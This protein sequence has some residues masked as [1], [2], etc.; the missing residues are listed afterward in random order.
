MYSH[1][2]PSSKTQQTQQNQQQDN[3]FPHNVQAEETT[4]GALIIDPDAILD[5]RMDEIG[6]TSEDFYLH[7]HKIIFQAIYELMHGDD[8]ACDFVLLS[9]KIE[10]MGKKDDIGGLAVL[11][12]LI[13]VTPSS[14]MVFDYAK[15]VK[16]LSDLR[17]G[18]YLS[19]EIAKMAFNYKNKGNIRPK[20][21]ELV[22][23][24]LDEK[25]EKGGLRHVS[26]TVSRFFDVL[27]EKMSTGGNP[28]TGLD[29]GIPDFN[30][31]TGGLNRQNLIVL[32]GRPGMG[33][34][35]MMVSIIAYLSMILNK[36]GAIFTL[37]MSNDEIMMKIL[38]SSAK[39]DHEKLRTGFGI[40]E[41]EASALNQHMRLLANSSLHIDDTPAISIAELS[42]KAR[43]LYWTHGLDY[44]MV[45]YLQ[46]MRGE[47]NHYKGNR[48]LEV[49]DISKGLKNLAKEL[50]IPVLALAQLSR[51]VENR[52]DKRPILADL[53]ES[54]S[55]EQDADIVAFIY[56][57]DMYDPETEY[58][59]IAEVLVRKNRHGSTGVFSMYFNKRQSTFVPLEIRTVM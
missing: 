42:T 25:S 38:S 19:Q 12:D 24:F 32:A 49:S 10:A 13:Q 53:R 56:R 28:I 57:D 48:Q 39:V 33:K 22:Y 50:N 18:I 36:K 2:D 15:I 29:V 5:K 3:L 45:D 23:K 46:L 34:S 40:S 41:D 54:G 20:I 17:K 16:E 4:L 1:H 51:A 30:R 11:G 43:K 55:I 31:L 26:E 8:M 37:E 35:S 21:E 6:L 52:A 47:H 14:I 7:K 59:N 44:I 9:D 58:P 27:S